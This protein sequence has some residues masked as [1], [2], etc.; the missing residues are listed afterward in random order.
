VSGSFDHAAKRAP[1]LVRAA[2]IPRRAGRALD[3][4]LARLVDR[5]GEPGTRIQGGGTPCATS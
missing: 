1:R 2:G 3:G 5:F 4:T